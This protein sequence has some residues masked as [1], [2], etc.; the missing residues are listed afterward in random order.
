MTDEAKLINIGKAF[1]DM[2]T[3][4]D[5]GNV[6]GTSLE[7]NIAFFEW[8]DQIYRMHVSHIEDNVIY[9]RG[10]HVVENEG[11]DEEVVEADIVESTKETGNDEV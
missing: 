10:L 1:V 4:I 8:G 6:K 3:K 2:M 9:S 11:S 5:S 7:K